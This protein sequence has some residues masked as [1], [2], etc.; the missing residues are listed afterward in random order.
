[1]AAD[2][3]YQV[4]EREYEALAVLR[5]VITLVADEVESNLGRVSQSLETLRS[6]V[7]SEVIRAES[8]LFY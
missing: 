2:M 5:D 7:N 6:N 8:E 4:T 1:M 3:S